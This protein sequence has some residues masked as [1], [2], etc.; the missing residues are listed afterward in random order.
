MIDAGLTL[1]FL[2]AFFASMVIADGSD[3]RG[4]FALGSTI[5]LAGLIVP[6]AEVLFVGTLGATPGKRA[7]GLRVVGPDGLRPRTWR[8]VARTGLLVVVLFAFPPLMLL[9]ALWI[10]LDRDHRGPHDLI[11][12]TKVVRT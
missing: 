12:G 5:V 7:L 1:A 2:A 9:V 10:A 4:W 8:A 3:S 6:A 11:G